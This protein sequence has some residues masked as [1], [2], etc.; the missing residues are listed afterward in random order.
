MLPPSVALQLFEALVLPIHEYERELWF[1]CKIYKELEQMNV[2]SQSIERWGGA[3]QYEDKQIKTL[4]I[5]VK[6][7]V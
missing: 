1:G 5:G 2:M 6:Y 4:N 3:H 7:C